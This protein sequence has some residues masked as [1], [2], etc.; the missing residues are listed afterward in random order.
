VQWEF[1]QKHSA[2]WPA[3]LRS[4]YWR[5]WFEIGIVARLSRSAFAPPPTVDAAVL[6]ITRRSCALV[7]LSEHRAYRR[8]LE[9]GF[10]SRVRLTRGLRRLL[11]PRQVRRAATVGGFD[12]YAFARDLDARQWA[13]LFRLRSGP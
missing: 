9:E 2:V 11:T 5:A 12:A 3:T 1:A 6:R 4:T 10:A 7:P 13:Q 8:F